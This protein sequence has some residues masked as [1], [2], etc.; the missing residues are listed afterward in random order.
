LIVIPA[1]DIKAGRCVRLQQGQMSKETVY[2]DAPEHM[3]VQW[4]EKGAERLHLVD[5]DGAMAGKPVN[6]EAIGRIISS[7]PIPIQLGGGIRTLELIETYLGLGIEQVILGTAAY[8]DPAFVSVACRKFPGRVILGI[9]A[10]KNQVAVEGWTEE[11]GLSPVTLAK[12]FDSV[13]ISAIIYTDIHRDGMRTGPNLKR[14][15]DLARAVD[16]PV[17]ASGGI[18]EI[19]DVADILPLSRYGVTGFIT[20]RALYEGSLD[21]TE[22]IKM[23]KE[24]KK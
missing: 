2:S 4:F 21:L 17:I 24:R 8:R 18:S 14:I 10:R 11:T 16:V 7:V 5:L 12:K 20:G 19:K 13:G 15:K 6:A 9:D 23:V 3:A 22:A 1:I